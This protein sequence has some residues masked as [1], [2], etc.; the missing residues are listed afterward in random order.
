MFK[1][2]FTTTFLLFSFA[3]ALEAKP[4]ADKVLLQGRVTDQLTGQILQGASIYFPELKKGVATN[5]KGNYQ[6]SLTQGKYLI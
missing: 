4:L 2:I 6:I 5:E 1:Y 3:L